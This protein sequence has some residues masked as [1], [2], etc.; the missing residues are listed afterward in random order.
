M[1]TYYKYFSL[2]YIGYQ[3]GSKVLAPNSNAISM[4]AR[5]QYF[6]KILKPCLKLTEMVL[7]HLISDTN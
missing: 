5:C 4:G 7:Q 2:I 6:L 1:V 3:K